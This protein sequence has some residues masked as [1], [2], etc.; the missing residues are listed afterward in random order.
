MDNFLQISKINDFLYSS[1]S[2]Y[3][4]Q[5]YQDYDIQTYHSSFQ[6][7][8]NI[9]HQKIDSGDYSS[10]K[11]YLSGIAVA[12][13]KYE[14]IGKIDVYDLQE[15]T[16]IERKYKIKTVH[17]G[18]IYQLYAQML[19]LQE[20]NYEVKKMCLHSLQDNKTYLIKMP[21]KNE[22]REF[23][24]VL[25]Q[26]KNYDLIAE[27]QKWQTSEVDEKTIYNPLYF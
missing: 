19:C 9:A 10:Q 15:K 8:G 16:L 25:N 5:I 7:R 2:I 23:L 20:M 3:F 14:L 24:E 12:S 22:L 1:K 27:S 13:E 6:T 11:K 21:T 4:H 18:Y 17:K 26:I